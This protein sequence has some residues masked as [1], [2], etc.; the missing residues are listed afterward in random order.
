MKVLGYFLSAV[1]AVL[2]G[3]AAHGEVRPISDAERAA[4]RVAADYL[5]RGPVAVV[6][7]LSSNS[8]L[9][10]LPA[11]DA[12]AEIEARL[13]PP[14]GATW[15]MQTVVPALKDKRAAFTVAFP[16]GIDDNVF[17]DL[18]KEGDAYRIEN[19]T[20]LA[21]PVDHEPFFPPLARR[22]ALQA[23]TLSPVDLATLS[24]FAVAAIVAFA[25]FIMH[26]GSAIGGRLL[27]LIGGAGAAT[28]TTWALM[29]AGHITFIDKS[30]DHAKN[31]A[32][33]RLG[34]LV[35]LRRATAAGLGDV[36]VAF[37]SAP[38]SGDAATAARLWKAQ[39]DLVQSRLDAVKRT[40][41]DFPV[42]SNIPLVELLRARLA[43]VQNDPASAVVAYNRAINIGPGRDA[44]W[45]EAAEVLDSEGFEERGEELLRRVEGIGTRNAFAYYARAVDEANNGHF[46]NSEAALRTAWSL[47]PIERRYLLRTDVLWKQLRKRGD[48]VV[49]VNTPDEASF[50]SASRSSRAIDLPQDAIAIV[51]GD[52]L[53]VRVGDQQLSVPGGAALAPSTAATADAGSLSHENEERALKDTPELT[54][55][56][57]T[58]G[59]YLQPVLRR[60]IIRVAAAL[61]ERNRWPDLEKLTA[62]VNAKSEFVPSDL[63]FYRSLALRRLNRID[64]AKQLMIEYAAS[65]TI[66][67]RN[68]AH[69]YE[70][71]GDSLA[72]F[73]VFDAAIKMYSK[74]K[75]IRDEQYDD[76]RI[77]QISMNKALATSYSVYT[78]PHFEIHYPGLMSAATALG[79]AKVLEAELTRLQK[80]VPVSNFRPVIVN[81]VP[82]ETF[83]SVY[84]GNDDILGFYE[85]KITLP[86]A[87]ITDLEP[88]IVSIVT[89][90]LCHAMIDQATNGQAPRWFHEG[91]AQRVEMVPYSP[92][93]FNMYEDN[94][95]FAV[96]LLDTIIGDAHDDGMIVAGYALS[97]T[98]IRY[99]EA[100]YGANATVQ[101]IRS[102]AAGA[103]SD[104][105][106]R[107][108][109]SQSVAK[110]DADFR[111]WGRAEKRVF[112]NSDSVVYTLSVEDTIQRAQPELPKK[113]LEGG[114]LHP[115][116]SG[117]SR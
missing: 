34:G 38:T 11:A 96:N 110:L 85:G 59:A 57:A 15:E 72:S 18:V 71:L 102:F 19:I 54:Q 63:F 58:S 14:A 65:P 22:A 8:P 41:D 32:A 113:K 42:P 107:N 117:Q 20:T 77:E 76:I 52:Y 7:Q 78:S 116:K 33:R 94:R 27:L 84:T 89:H 92:N 10:R 103:T 60:R 62:S 88:E 51:S 53:H 28:V 36:G 23:T 4:V 75:A 48:S 31:V 83:K 68:D 43:L 50:A 106:L 45:L 79:V 3:A 111:T 67:R 5:A 26:R 90:E 114:T 69:T 105:A 87:G 112:E 39:A 104:E 44:L 9:R 66:A 49:N 86:L 91:L 74:A 108:L 95:F 13:G 99:L 16:S 61:S 35:A 73:D 17:F 98:F 101:L 81:I 93:A 115:F 40:V 47:Q 82:W 12:N 80:W 6:E 64:E 109:S 56:A 25:L 46:A 97:Q 2:F 24:L 37:A 55:A 100:K 70:E 30:S 29:S 1:A 21:E